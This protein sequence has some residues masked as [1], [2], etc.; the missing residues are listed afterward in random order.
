MKKRNHKG[1]ITTYL[2]VIGVM[3]AIIGINMIQTALFAGQKT[4]YTSEEAINII[5]D[6]ESITLKKN[7]ITFWVK[8][9]QIVVDDE[10][11]G[12]IKGKVFHPFGNIFTM[13]SSNGDVIMSEKE[14]ILHLNKQAQFYNANGNEDGRLE[15]AYFHILDYATYSGVEGKYIYDQA[16]SI[17][18]NA[19]IKDDNT[20]I[21]SIKKQFW[22][23]NYTITKNNEGVSTIKAAMMTAIEDSIKSHSSKSSSS[24]KK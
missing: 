10:I 21:F 18:Y 14:E 7:Y 6:A 12:E 13:Y 4:K 17:R 15:G 20:N 2:I 22:F 9:Y 24:S 8:D 11:V 3:V 1:T 19:V 5:N 16:F 23:D